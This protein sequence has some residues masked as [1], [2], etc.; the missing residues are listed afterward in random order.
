M[1]AAAA[2]S[3]VGRRI[4]LLYGPTSSGKSQLAILLKKGLEAYSMTD[5]GA[6]YALAES[7]MH[8]DPLLAVPSELRQVFRDEYGIN[9]SGELTPLMSLLLKEKYDGDFL[10]L[11]VKRVVISERSRVGIGTFVPSLDL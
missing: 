11:P 10:K 2:G 9:I 4:L 3:E 7:P 1:R 8:E 5:S 6:I